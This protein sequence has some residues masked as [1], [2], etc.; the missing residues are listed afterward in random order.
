MGRN[1]GLLIIEYRVTPNWQKA[2]GLPSIFHAEDHSD[3]PRFQADRGIRVFAVELLRRG[4]ASRTRLL[5]G[6]DE[7]LD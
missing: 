1:V 7:S 5:A 6:S 3:L 4:F 2:D